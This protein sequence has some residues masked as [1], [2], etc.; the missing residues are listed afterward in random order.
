MEDVGFG[1]GEGLDF[2][3]DY[4]MGEMIEDIPSVKPTIPVDGVDELLDEVPLEDNTITEEQQ[5]LA[6]KLDKSDQAIQNAVAEMTE[7]LALDE[8]DFEKEQAPNDDVTVPEQP[9][10]MSFSSTCNCTTNSLNLQLILK[11]AF[12]SVNA[13][14]EV[15][16]LRVYSNSIRTKSV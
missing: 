1:A 9:T 13:D 15:L 6:D 14:I 7:D 2:L 8:V 3:E 11:S 4:G 16:F 12:A 10:G 5:S